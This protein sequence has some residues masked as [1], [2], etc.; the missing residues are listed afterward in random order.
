LSFINVPISCLQWGSDMMSPH[1]QPNYQ[2]TPSGTS[3]IVRS[4]RCE[5]RMH[6]HEF[7]QASKQRAEIY[8]LSSQEN[9]YSQTAVSKVLSRCSRIPSKW[10]SCA[11]KRKGSQ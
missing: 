10:S 6:Q 9:I 1:L 2:G 4:Q 7:K 3:H 8:Q 5:T 11:F